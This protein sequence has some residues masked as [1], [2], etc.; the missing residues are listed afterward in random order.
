MPLRVYTCTSGC[1]HKETVLVG[2]EPVPDKCPECGGLLVRAFQDE[3]P[4]VVGETTVGRKL[5]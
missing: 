1:G 5:P 3:V 4:T 2:H